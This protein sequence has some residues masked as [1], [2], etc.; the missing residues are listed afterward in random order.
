M[1]E[2]CIRL[3]TSLT[4]D[5]EIG[6]IVRHTSEEDGRVYVHLYP[7]KSMP[8][9]VLHLDEHTVPPMIEV[10]TMD[11]AQGVGLFSTKRR[12]HGAELYREPYPWMHSS[13][14]PQL[15]FGCASA[16][17]SILPGSYVCGQCNQYVCPSCVV[18]WVG[19]HSRLCGDLFYKKQLHVRGKMN[20]YEVACLPYGIM[21]KI[22]ALVAETGVSSV[23]DLPAIQHL[24]RADCVYKADMHCMSCMMSVFAMVKDKFCPTLS[25]HVFLELTFRLVAN[26]FP[27]P[28]GGA[29]LYRVSGLMNTSC[30]G[31]ARVLIDES[32]GLSLT[33]VA[34]GRIKSGQQLYMRNVSD[35][36]KQVHER[37]RM[38]YGLTCCD[39]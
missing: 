35:D 19:V 13:P 28:S 23:F 32:D 26:L 1:T 17:T 31:T 15:C 2:E 36:R 25:I 18:P 12:A 34:F 37:M 39:K 9:R 5:E 38:L 4:S 8:A 3:I 20:M 24:E 7:D 30:R 29:A 11:D 21:C 22:L 27:L 16:M 10:R 33:V 6:D 14:I